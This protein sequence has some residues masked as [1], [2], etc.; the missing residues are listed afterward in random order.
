MLFRSAI[1]FSLILSLSPSLSLSLSPPS[2]FESLLSRLETV[3]VYKASE[4]G[5]E[6][7]SFCIRLSDSPPASRPCFIPHPFISAFRLSLPL[8]PIHPLLCFSPSIRPSIHPSIHPFIH[9]AIT[10]LITPIFHDCTLYSLSS[11]DVGARPGEDVCVHI[12]SACTACH[13]KLEYAGA[14]KPHMCT[15]AHVCMGGGIA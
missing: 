3:V 12:N 8:C 2:S 15:Y 1:L 11:S 9:H 10:P 14:F 4:Q 7:F 5:Q 13:V 6:L